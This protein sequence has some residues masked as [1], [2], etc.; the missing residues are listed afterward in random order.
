MIRLLDIPKPSQLTD[1]LVASL[2]AEHKATGK[3]VWR[4][5]YLTDA[6]YTMGR[7]KCAFCELKFDPHQSKYMEVDHFKPK[8]LFKDDVL[9]WGNLLPICKRC[10]VKKGTLDVT[11]YPI[12][13]PRHDDP[14]N[15]LFVRRVEVEGLV[16]FLLRGKT[17][18]GK[19][20]I[21]RLGLLEE[22][23]GLST[24]LGGK[25]EGRNELITRIEKDLDRLN[26]LIVETDWQTAPSKK[27]MRVGNWLSEILA[28]AQPESQYAAIVSSALLQNLGFQEICDFLKG[29]GRWSLEMEVSLTNATACKLDV[30]NKQELS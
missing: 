29:N 10:N 7:G 16:G 17:D 30:V 3:E 5:K 1:E 15:H 27:W 8:H 2:T 9:Q 22:D 26:A 24:D 28:A 13:N 23:L 20:T 18:M 11:V 4:M 12:L 19:Q 6:L 14:R 21:T 25:L